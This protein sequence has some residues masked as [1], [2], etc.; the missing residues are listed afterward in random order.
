MALRYLTKGSSMPSEAYLFPETSQKTNF[1]K[2]F[3]FLRYLHFC[4]L[5]NLL[6]L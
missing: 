6:L 5:R 3:N 1:E 2:K 4:L